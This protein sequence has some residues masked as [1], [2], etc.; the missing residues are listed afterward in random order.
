MDLNF[1]RDQQ[2][3]ELRPGAR[4]SGQL[5]GVESGI[6]HLVTRFLVVRMAKYVWLVLEFCNTST[7]SWETSLLV[8]QPQKL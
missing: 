6:Y 4:S 3:I 2:W 1:P 8:G 7:L 5:V